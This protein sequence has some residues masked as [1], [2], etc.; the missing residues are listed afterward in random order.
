MKTLP[1]KWINLRALAIMA[2]GSSLLFSC[3]DDKK[4]GG[5]CTLDANKHFK[6]DKIEKLNIQLTG[7]T[8]KV[9]PAFDLYF[10]F[11][12]TMKKSLKDQAFKDLIESAFY[13]GGESV[14][15]YSI[16]ENPQLTP[17]AGGM[18]EKKNE[19][20]SE[21]KY[22][23]S[24]TFMTPNLSNI[25][26]NLDR[27]AFMFTDFSVDEGVA[28]TSMSDG[29]NS[30]YVRGPEFKAQFQKWFESGGSVRVYGKL[31]G[32]GPK[33]P[34]YVL[35]F[36]PAGFDASHK[37]NEVLN[38]L[39]RDMKK[40]IYLDYH[41]N[42]VSFKG[43]DN[44][45]FSD[46]LGWAMRG[47]SAA[48]A[49]GKGEVHIY[50]GAKLLE[51]MKSNGKVAGLSMFQ[52]LSYTVDTTAF[53]KA[54]VFTSVCNEYACASKEELDETMKEAKFMDAIIQDASSQTIYTPAKVD[55]ANKDNNYTSNRFY[56][57]AINLASGELNFDDDKA[58]KMLQYDLMAGKNKIK[59]NCLYQSIKQAL[60]SAVSSYKPRTVYTINAFVKQAEKK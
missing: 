33:T 46:S 4:G 13:N 1:S 24:M 39:N 25:A 40:D 31:L 45:Q 43:G 57:L 3:G 11:S 2:L 20:L 14:N 34:I 8:L 18:A 35:A 29:V 55:Y 36:L 41:S 6:A 50:D 27:P 37:A 22:T 19:I 26:Q 59:N 53:M 32:D 51:N 48:F 7:D 23:Q 15:C 54:P 9:N 28:T 44:E 38:L 21:V 49:N 52:G 5:A 60:T 58:A 42:F 17:I 30:T 10:D 12:S 16:G 56:R 47:K